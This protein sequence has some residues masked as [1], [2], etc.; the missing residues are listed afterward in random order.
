MHLL[1]KGFMEQYLCWYAHIEPYVPYETM[2]ERIAGS[3]S[4]A[5]NVYEV[6]NDNSNLYRTM[7]M[8]TIRMN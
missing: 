2:V 3:T 6:V 4:S 1:Q 7:V 5:N 8:D